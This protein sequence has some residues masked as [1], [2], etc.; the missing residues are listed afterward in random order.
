VKPSD[1]TRTKNKHLQDAIKTMVRTRV[2]R[3]LSTEEVI[4]RRKEGWKFEKKKRQSGIEIVARGRF[5]GTRKEM[6]YGPHSDERWAIIENVDKIRS[7]FLSRDKMVDDIVDHILD[8]VGRNCLHR[9][10]K[11]FCTHWVFD[12]LPES[13]KQLDSND[14]NFLIKEITHGREPS[15]F[16]ISPIFRICHICPAYIDEKMLSFIEAIN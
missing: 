15:E 12:K 6:G 5:N 2:K 13:S 3:E 4:K 16:L 9:D 10:E 1:K 14:F 11:G 7:S 8:F